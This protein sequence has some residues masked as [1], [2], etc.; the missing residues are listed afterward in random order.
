MRWKDEFTGE[1][2]TARKF[3]LFPKEIDNEVRWMEYA[4][5]QQSCFLN[6]KHGKYWKDV[7]W[8]PDHS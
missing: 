2:R 8:I 1:M 6:K 4:Y 3:L 5:I 7:A